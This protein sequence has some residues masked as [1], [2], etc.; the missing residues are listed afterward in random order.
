VG[1]GVGGGEGGKVVLRARKTMKERKI[2]WKMSILRVERGRGC[3]EDG[4][5]VG[6]I[7]EMLRWGSSLRE[8]W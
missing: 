7:R 5:G 1:G 4:E 6:M 3:R 2:M 8:V